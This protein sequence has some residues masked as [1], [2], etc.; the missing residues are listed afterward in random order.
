MI[1]N[2]QTPLLVTHRHPYPCKTAVTVTENV[3]VQL[4]VRMCN[5]MCARIILIRACKK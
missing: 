1:G 5:N 4:Q 2:T 3:H